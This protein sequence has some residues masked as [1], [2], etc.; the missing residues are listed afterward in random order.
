MGF[1]ALDYAVLAAYLAGIMIF[2]AQFR[3]R[4][5]S[6]SDY[7]IGSRTTSWWVI[8]LSIVATETSP[9]TLIGVPG[10]AF[11]TYARPEQGGNLTYLQ[12]VAGYIVARVL[13][14]WLFIPA[15]FQGEML[16]AYELLQR[17]FGTR[18]KHFTAALFLLMR[19]LAEG[20]RVFAAS[21]VLT[22]VI[23]GP[24]A[25]VARVCAWAA[26][27]VRRLTLGYTL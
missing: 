16:T 2:G 7:F 22:A 8:S 17:R 1:S 18:A 4:Y 27:C 21:L 3:S 9:P 5:S 25:G 13:I 12:V 14:A 19:P 11:A 26:L 23:S 15:Y 20:V 6:V 10:I 24:L